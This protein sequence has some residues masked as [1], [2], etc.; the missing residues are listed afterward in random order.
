MILT[1]LKQ[2]MCKDSYLSYKGMTHNLKEPF[3]FVK[4]EIPYIIF[5]VENRCIPSGRKDYEYA[6]YSVKDNCCI[7]KNS[8]NYHNIVSC[9]PSL[10]NING[11][12]LAP[13]F[14]QRRVLSEEFDEILE[15]LL[16]EG[17]MTE[18][19]KRRYISYLESAAKRKKAAVKEVYCYFADI[20]ENEKRK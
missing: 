2:L 7:S 8:N 6:V 5:I 16:E 11:F 9:L 14:E 10:D 20:L 13:D 4:D 18:D 17:K 1:E 15:N 3:I 12:N 19:N